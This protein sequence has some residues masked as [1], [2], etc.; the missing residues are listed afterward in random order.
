[1]SLQFPIRHRYDSNHFTRIKKPAILLLTR[2]NN[3][4]RLFVLITTISFMLHA[5]R[6]QEGKPVAVSGNEKFISFEEK[7]K[8]ALPDK[9]PVITNPAVAG[10]NFRYAARKATPGVVH[11]KSVFTGK[12]SAGFFQRFFW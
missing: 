12:G 5:C 6:G 1:M 3:M 7:Q 11:I 4:K 2:G 8:N 10:F 9:G